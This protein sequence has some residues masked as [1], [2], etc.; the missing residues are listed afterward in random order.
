MIPPS[1]ISAELEVLLP[2]VEKPGRYT[3]GELNQVVKNW[4]ATPVKVALIF[5]DIYDL[6][7]SNLGL[8]ILYDQLNQHPDVLAER[9]YAPWI[10]M[11][12]SMRGAALP[13]YSLETKHAIRDFDLIG[14][15]FP[16]ETLYTNALNL[17]DLSHI[18][19]YARDRD[20]THPLVLAGGQAVFNPEPM[21]DFMDGFVI[22]EGEDVI[23]EII[24]VYKAW[25]TQDKP[26]SDLL[27][28]LA[29]IDGMYIP[30]FYA[31]EYST[32]GQ[33]T[34]IA[35]RNGAA[36][37]IKKRIVNPLPPPPTKMIVPYVETAH[38][39]VTIEI[40]RGCTRGCRFCHA[41]MV[42]R[43]VRERPAEEI[44]AT[45]QKSILA[46]GYEEVGL[47]SLSSSDYTQIMPLL[48]GIRDL[49]KSPSFSHQSVS[50]SLPSLRIE[51]I[52]EELIDILQDSKRQGFTVAPEA[53]SERLR[54]TINKPIPADQFSQM[55]KQIFERGYTTIKLYFLIGLP[56]EN[57]EDILAIAD[58]CK[59]V[60]GEGKRI[61]GGRAQVNVSVNTFVPKPHTPFQWVPCI[62]PE[63]IQ[64]K[65]SI[66]RSELRRLPI[67]LTWNHAEETMLEALLSRGSRRLGDVIFTAWQNG[68]KFDAWQDQFKPEIWKS[69]LQTCG[70]ERDIY[71]HRLR[72]LTEIFPWDHIHAGVS[73]H[74]LAADYQASRLGKTRPD[75][76]TVCH[77][78]GISTDY[79]EIYK[80]VCKKKT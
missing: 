15:S 70:I 27:K 16:Y 39:R 46:T 68:A 41:G 19:L 13:L 11:E 26:R 8:A 42:N 2:F 18:P 34:H 37:W 59:N 60:L 76:R 54:T 72:E 3:G 9:A 65:I 35:N 45:I 33:I 47:L 66:L 69:A 7:M 40:M 29:T 38:N 36:A 4:D 58:L 10:D 17:L 24:A 80:D 55:V 31:V 57:E 23:H 77:A 21:A 49:Q 74:F 71:I 63:E 53:A 67:K 75:C 20:D 12:A 5:P 28:S 22:G 78:C 73:K 61:V 48:K 52:T 6:G 50:I 44:I 56:G 32:D 25:K 30:S 1:S 51:S 79:I 14:F 64:S 62:T 43:P